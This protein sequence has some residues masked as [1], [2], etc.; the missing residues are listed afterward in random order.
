MYPALSVRLFRRLCAPRSALLI[1]LAVAGVA[2]CDI[3]CSWF[4]PDAER[5]RSVDGHA[6]RVEA[7]GTRHVGVDAI[8][9]PHAFGVLWP[10][11]DGY[12]YELSLRLDDRPEVG[13]G[14]ATIGEERLPTE[15]E[16]QVFADALEVG[17]SSDGDHLAYRR[18]DTTGWRVLHLLSVGIPFASNESDAL[19]GSVVAADALDFAAFPRAQ[20]IAL[21]MLADSSGAPRAPGCVARGERAAGRRTLGCRVARDWPDEERAY[22]GLRRCV[23][24]GSGSTDAF[25]R[26]AIAKALDGLRARPGHADAQSA[27]IVASG[28]ADAVV[29]LD[30]TLLELAVR[31]DAARA[32][33]DR[34]DSRGSPAVS[35]VVRAGARTRALEILRGAGV[36]AQRARD[37]MALLQAATG[38]D[39]PPELADALLTLWPANAAAHDGLLSRVD[40]LAPAIT[41]RLEHATRAHLGDLGEAGARAVMMRCRLLMHAGDCAE[42]RSLVA[43]AG[44]TATG[45]CY[46]PARC[47]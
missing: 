24:P 30:V 35:S 21:R 20:V 47:E 15:A 9:A 25:R 40:D 44:S 26:A 37:S 14:Q 43:R 10:V 23:A 42:I 38:S 32:L 46:E 11:I 7:Q 3:D 29:T 4:A 6:I 18:D 17:L 27:L 39:E 19:A 41:S 22:D 34:L 5:M 13:L 12:G 33:K 8:A 2:A 36:D 1:V 45:G 31:P 28:R 16:L